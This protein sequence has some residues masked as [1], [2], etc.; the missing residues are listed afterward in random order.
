MQI[1]TAKL[2]SAFVFATW[3]AHFLFVLNPKFQAASLLL[4]LYSSVCV[5]RVR[6]PHYWF[7]H[8][9]APFIHSDDV[10]MCNIFNLCIIYYHVGGHTDNDASR[11]LNKWSLSDNDSPVNDIVFMLMS[12]RSCHMP[13]VSFVTSITERKICFNILFFISLTQYRL[14]D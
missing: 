1:S 12:V 11:N 9:A 6:K 7:S 2:S 4:C 14:M 8:E 5:G 13:G 10:I 3:I